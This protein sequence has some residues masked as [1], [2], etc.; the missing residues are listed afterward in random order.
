MTSSS[1]IVLG[2]MAAMVVVAGVILLWPAGDPERSKVALLGCKAILEAQEAYYFGDD[3]KDGVKDYAVNLQELHETKPGL[4]DICLV[5]K[6]MAGADATRQDRIPKHGYY[7]KILTPSK[8]PAVRQ[9]Q[10]INGYAI[11]AFPAIVPDVERHPTF[12]LSKNGMYKKWLGPD[13]VQAAEA[14][15]DFDPDDSWKVVEY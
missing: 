12:L 5:D 11:L 14:I 7:Y 15:H 6:A 13:P 4:S 3:D 9:K 8:D 10:K 2:L 1:K